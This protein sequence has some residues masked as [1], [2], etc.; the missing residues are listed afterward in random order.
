MIDITAKFVRVAL[1]YL[2]KAVRRLLRQANRQ[3][4][5]QTVPSLNKASA[6]ALPGLLRLLKQVL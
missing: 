5:R 2:L 3:Q 6:M 1:R 4:D